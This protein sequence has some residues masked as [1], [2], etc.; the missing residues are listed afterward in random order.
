MIKICLAQID[1]MLGDK[2]KNL[3]NIEHYCRQAKVAGAKI[4][5]LSELA[6]TGYSPLLLGKKYHSLGEKKY[7]KT[8]TF[9]TQLSTELNLVIIC[10]FVEK[11][12]I[13]HKIYNSAGVWVPHR[14]SWLGVY[15]KLHLMPDEKP[16]FE[17]GNT[18]PVFDI[19]ICRIGIMICYD[20]GFPEVARAL[21][22]KDADILFMPSAWSEH[23][24]DIW[25]IH[26][27][28]RALENTVHL[29]AVN[30][31]GQEGRYQLFGGSR[32][33]G[34]RG[35]VLVEATEGGEQS[36]YYS[37]D[38]NLQKETRES[39]FYLVDRKKNYCNV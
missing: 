11:D 19:G 33:V 1:T 18:L 22:V 5:C 14:Q 39:L 32:V 30:R 31:W 27:S 8:D 17:A 24:R 29:I 23:D 35:Q 3:R 12:D 37:I 36:I 26:T 20:V 21:T 34:P 15:R 13:S 38:P 9:F 4:I 28:C 2:E 25:H 6:T 16:W 10:G 7:E